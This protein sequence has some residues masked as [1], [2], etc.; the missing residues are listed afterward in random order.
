MKGKVNVLNH[1][2]IILEIRKIQFPHCI[3]SIDNSLTFQHEAVLIF[4]LLCNIAPQVKMLDSDWL[5]AGK[6]SMCCPPLRQCFPARWGTFIMDYHVVEFVTKCRSNETLMNAVTVLVVSVG[7]S[8][9]KCHISFC[10]TSTIEGDM[11]EF[12]THQTMT[13]AYTQG[14][15]D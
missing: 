11:D 12:V 14:A 8:S 6:H 7:V 13:N 9:L 4:T 5:T 3:A 15:G 2:G 1:C 10:N